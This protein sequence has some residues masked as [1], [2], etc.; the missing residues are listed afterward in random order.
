MTIWQPG[1]VLSPPFSPGMSG[2]F[3]A[4]PSI[5]CVFNAI[6]YFYFVFFS[7][8]IPPLQIRN[9]YWVY[10]A[11]GVFFMSFPIILYIV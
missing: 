8:P 4:A 5:F 1:T 9:I 11:G 10:C 2:L 6:G 3:Q 7:S